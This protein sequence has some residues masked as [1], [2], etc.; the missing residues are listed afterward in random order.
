VLVLTSTYVNAGVSP[1]K[2]VC[3]LFFLT[4]KLFNDRFLVFTTFF[5]SCKHFL[6][7]YIN[8]IFSLF[9]AYVSTVIQP[10]FN[11]DCWFDVRYLLLLLVFLRIRDI[12]FLSTLVL[13]FAH[14]ICDIYFY[15]LSFA[16]MRSLLCQLQF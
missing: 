1:I 14:L 15:C 8:A 6:V 12:Y 2:F 10:C 16:D 5:Y 9:I 3:K 11:C 7:F 13:V 4:F